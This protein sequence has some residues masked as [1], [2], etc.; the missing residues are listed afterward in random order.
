MKIS[1]GQSLLIRYV[2]LLIKP[3]ERIGMV[4]NARPDFLEGLEYDIYFSDRK[5]AIEFNGDQHYVNTK[6]YGSCE[7]QIKR[8]RRKLDLSKKCGV[9]LVSIDACHLN[10]KRMLGLMYCL[11]FTGCHNLQKKHSAELAILDREASE[12]RKHLMK[13]FPQI[14]TVYNPRNR[15]RMIADVL[16]GRYDRQ[17]FQPGDKHNWVTSSKNNRT[18]HERFP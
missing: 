7:A 11:R 17:G 3:K 9:F 10:Q 12:Y 4:I 13:N 1:K 2:E 16:A 14:T 5:K 6:T 8:D 18:T 15:S